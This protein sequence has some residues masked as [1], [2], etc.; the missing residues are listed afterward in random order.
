MGENSGKVSHIARYRFKYLQFQKKKRNNCYYNRYRTLSDLNIP[1]IFTRNTLCLVFYLNFPYPV[2]L[3]RFLS[4]KRE[5]REGSG[6]EVTKK[7]VA[8]G[9]TGKERK[10]N[11]A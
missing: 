4:C 5:S 10:Q 7:L 3:F 8:G 1:L 2:S 9:G 11:K 6:T